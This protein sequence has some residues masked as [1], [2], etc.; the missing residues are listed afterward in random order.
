MYACV[1]SRSIGPM[2]HAAMTR[3]RNCSICGLCIVWRNSGWPTRKLCRS[4]CVSSWKLDSMRSSSTAR[5]VR[6]CAS[7]MMS[8]ARLPC[9]VR[10]TRKASR[11]SSICDFGTS[12]V[13]SP[14]AAATRRSVSSASSCVLTSWAAT[15]FP[16]SSLRQEAAHD[17]GLA[18]ADLAGHH[19]EA[20]VLMQAVL[21]IRH[22]APV[23]AAPEVERGIRVELEGL[24]GQAVEGFVHGGAVRTARGRWR[25]PR[26]RDSRWPC[27]RRRTPRACLRARTAR[28]GEGAWCT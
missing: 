4:A 22:R 12:L 21:E 8:S 28:C 24:V 7:S 10:L 5:G 26:S 13:A 23:L 1:S 11:P 6:F 18:G 19:D 27:R 3:W 15:T 9:C 25:S 20:F 16:G 17:R 2:W 14:K